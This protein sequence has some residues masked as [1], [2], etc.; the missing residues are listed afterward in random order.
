MDM[1]TNK[2]ETTSEWY[3]KMKADGFEV[4]LT[5]YHALIKLTKD[6]RISFQDAY[7]ALEDEGRIKVVNKTINFD[8]NEN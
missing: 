8:L 2:F 3:K 1:D 5:L 4:P 7:K 6:K